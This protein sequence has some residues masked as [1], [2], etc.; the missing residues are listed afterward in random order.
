M[1][2]HPDDD[3]ANKIRQQQMA[4]GAPSPEEARAEHDRYLASQGCEVCG[5]TDIHRLGTLNPFIP[6]CPALQHPGGHPEPPVLCI[7]HVR[8]PREFW[9]AEQ[10]QRARRRGSVAIAVYGCGNVRPIDMPD[11]PEGRFSDPRVDSWDDVPPQVR[12][13]PEAPIHCECGALIEE[14]REIA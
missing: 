6:S 13:V 2:I 8:S 11:F 10:V 1:T 7:E 5:M 12:P 14:V 9:W 4:D 3:M